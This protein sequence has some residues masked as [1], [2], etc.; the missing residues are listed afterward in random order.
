MRHPEEN[1]APHKHGG[2][3]GSTGAARG[4]AETKES[5]SFL[6]KRSKK[7]F[8]SWAVLV[9]PPPAQISKSFLRRFFFKKAATSF[10]LPPIPL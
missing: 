8:C 1:S 2:A 7:L 9:S 10:R 3:E 6:K 4:S 5:A